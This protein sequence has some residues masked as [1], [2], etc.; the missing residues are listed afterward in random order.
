MSNNEEI[1]IFPVARWDFGPVPSLGLITIR[2]HFL[3][4]PMQAMEQAQASRF[5]ALTKSQARELIEDL[6][7]ALQ[8]L[9][10]HGESAAGHQK[11]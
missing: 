8:K 1:P 7:K 6:Q 11:H 4:G 2:P 3:S 10:T 9:E 5:Y